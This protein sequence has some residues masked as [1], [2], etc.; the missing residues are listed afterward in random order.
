MRPIVVDLF[1][2]A[3]GMSLGFEQAGFDVAA[4]VEYNPVA[5]AVH[6]FNFPHSAVLCDSVVN[7][8]GTDI[9]ARSQIGSKKVTCVI[10]GPPCQG[11]SLIG[12]RILDDPR[13]SLVLDFV[14][15]VAELDS[16]YFVFENVK[17]L[18]LGKHRS[19]LDELYEAFA[20]AGYTIKSPWQVLNAA[21]Y[22]TPQR[23]ERLIL[24]GSKSGLK[25]PEYPAQTHRAPDA[26]GGFW[27]E[28]PMGPNVGDAFEGLPE[29]EKYPSLLVSDEV[30]IEVSA[31]SGW[32]ARELAVVEDSAW[33]NGVVRKWQH[34]LVTSSTRT[35]H[36]KISI[37]RFSET[38]P[39][40]V[41]P[42]SRFPR[43]SLTGISPT[44][45]A[46]SDGSRGAFTSPRPIHPVSPR[47]ITVR[48]MARLHGIPDW[49]RLHQTKWHGAME[50]GNAVAV[51][52]A[53]AIGK[54]LADAIAYI[55]KH[56][57]KAIDLGNPQ[58]LTLDGS[59]AALHFGITYQAQKRDRKSTA[60]K[61]S[62]AETEEARQIS[63]KSQR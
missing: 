54:S 9:R 32:Y 14:R 13:N 42:F 19:F 36:S 31:P 38:L 11:F 44:L 16:D 51:P 20:R 46:G 63:K 10:G 53:R 33:H 58:L 27:P 6:K 4:A 15:L 1:A 57:T 5:A 24:L 60:K 55:P 39:G 49:F 37:D 47:C 50:V 23:R 59:G 2:G 41:E 61:R 62:Q 21:D 48:E 43:L 22:G 34:N 26:P 18:T 7:L 8:T 35:L 3:G 30:E 56:S 29:V 25:L 28:L 17:G 52:L 40:T 45:R 12:K